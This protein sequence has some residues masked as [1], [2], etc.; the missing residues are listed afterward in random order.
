MKRKTAKTKIISFVMMLA[1]LFTVFP[2]GGLRVVAEDSES[3]ALTDT[4]PVTVPFTDAGPLMEPVTGSAIRYKVKSL[5]LSQAYSLAAVQDEQE[6]GLILD[7]NVTPNGDG[8]YTISLES[9][10]TGTVTTETKNIPTD[11]VLVLDQSGSMAES[12][13]TTT[14]YTPYDGRS[15][16]DLYYR[17]GNL[18]HKLDNGTYV[19]VSVSRANNSGFNEVS[20]W[21]NYTY[22]SQWNPLYHLHVDGTYHQVTIKR[23]GGVGNRTYTYTCSDCS[24]SDQSLGWDTVP[25]FTNLGTLYQQTDVYTYTYTYTD[26]EGKPQ[27]ILTS[28]GANTVPGVVFYRQGTE[29]ES[30]LAALTEAVDTFVAEINK[31][32]AGTDGT[33]GTDDDVDHRI[34]MVGFASER[35]YEGR[36]YNYGNTALFVG[37]TQYTYNAGAQNS[38]TNANA[39]Q[40]HYTDAFQ[41]MSTAAG[42]TNVA[43]SIEAL[44][45]NGGTHIQLGM[46]MANGIL[47]ANPL[48]EGEQRNRVVIVFTDGTPGWS[49]F[50][51]TVANN[52]ISQ[53]Y[54]TKNTHGATV[55]TVGIFAGASVTP[56]TL[57][58]G[59]TNAN[60]F[61][62]L[63]SSNYKT[64]ASMTNTGMSTWP[65]NGSSYYLTADDADSLS[66]IFTS[67]SSQI[68]SPAISLGA[69]TQLRDIVT[70]YFTMPNNVN[71]IKIYTAQ[72]TA[73]PSLDSITWGSRTLTDL[74]PTIDGRTITV[75]G[76]DYD[77]NFVSVNQHTDGTYG[78]KLIIEFT[79]IL[80]DGFLGGNAVPTNGDTSGVYTSDG[81]LVETFEVPTVDVPIPDVSVSVEDKNV[82]LLH[83]PTQEEL[84]S[85]GVTVK[86]G[87]TP[88]NLTAENYGLEA[89]QTAYV[90]IRVTAA[91]AAEFD[92]TADSSTYTV[93]ASVDPTAEGGSAGK[94]NSDTQELFVYKPV[95]TW[96][97]S[98]I[99]LGAT[100]NYQDNFVSVEWKHGETSAASVTMIGS[101]PTLGYAY[102]PAAAAFTADTPVNVTTS[103]GDRDVTGYVTYKH[104]DCSFDGCQWKKDDGEFIVHIKSCM[105]TISKTG[106]ADIDE[107]QTFLFEVEGKGIKLTVAVHGN[108]SAT[109]TDLPVGTY[110]VT[111]KTDWSWRYTPQQAEQQVQAVA[112]E[113]TVTFANNRTNTKWL[114]GG[115]YKN[116]IYGVSAEVPSESGN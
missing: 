30:K 27:T 47:A 45:A 10:T 50:D 97:D 2:A 74:Q 111:E 115:C 24:L 99:D 81:T 56:G 96:K 101:E 17:S 16:S 53:A 63:L 109:V 78:Q 68:E 61:M 37:S 87:N 102:N 11:I 54:T 94:T 95:I 22:N 91:P 28:E 35:W 113:N 88:L 86:V 5:M 107:N 71:D 59:D 25:V 46:E 21:N 58:E 36:N 33:L 112:G 65:L 98:E 76:F 106:C 19:P 3:A 8:S 84:L 26:G 9:Y 18:Y 66:N 89:W 23:S 13:G 108:S 93:T 32:A 7:K 14:V 62:N 85:G 100:A 110:T 60:R 42:Q 51:E 40:Q 49:G 103:I 31:K 116:N 90:N 38:P 20:E 55:Y 39:A 67:I 34:A 79:V 80:R 77:A 41:D 12:F 29:D 69:T 92:A 104:S 83:V 6:S 82:Y 73:V 72:A 57:P 70:P 75:S 44:S 114:D 43:A 48:G 15:N 4:A 1:F 64:A 52:A 105:L